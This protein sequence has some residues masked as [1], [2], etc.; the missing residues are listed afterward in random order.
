MMLNLKVQDAINEQIKNELYSAYLYLAMSAHFEAES[1]AGFA[2]WTR[3][4]AEEEVE[5]AMK[6]FDYVSERGGRVTLQGI[7]QPPIDFGPPLEVFEMI[8][9]H[10]QKVS[11]LIHKLYETALL[12]KDYATQVMLHWFIEEQVEEEDNASLMVDQLK[13]AEDHQMGILQLDHQAGKRAEE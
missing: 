1:L 12:E 13:M 8:Y 3:M 7:D 2:K 11:S 9:A 5:H 10:E 6:L 4:Q